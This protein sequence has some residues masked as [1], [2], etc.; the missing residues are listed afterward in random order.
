MPRCS[1]AQL[2]RTRPT[3]YPLDAFKGEMV[4]IDLG[5]N[6]A[7]DGYR[8][9]FKSPVIPPRRHGPARL[10]SSQALILVGEPGWDRTIDLL[11]KSQCSTTE[12]RA[13]LPVH[14]LNTG[15]HFQ[16]AFP[17]GAHFYGRFAKVTPPGELP[18]EDPA[19]PIVNR[20]ADFHTEITAWR[21]DI[22]AHPELLYDV[23]RTAAS[24]AEKLKS[25]GCDEVVPGIGRTGVVGVIRGRKA[26]RQGD[27]AARRHGRAA[28]RGGNRLALQVDRPRQDA[29][30]RP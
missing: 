23:H 30:L 3:A 26:G 18:C 20:V 5:E 2:A 4:R 11:I 21:R 12:L 14:L 15:G 13:R 17:V 25:F 28:D 8:R 19:M 9:T 7:E 16:S 24:V 1:A 29:R 22:H 27:R 6:S 10:D